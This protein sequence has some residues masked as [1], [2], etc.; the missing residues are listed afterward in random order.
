[1]HQRVSH[2]FVDRVMPPDVFADNDK[3]AGGIKESRRVQSAR[4]LENALMSPKLV[5]Q[6]GQLL[7]GERARWHYPTTTRMK[8]VN[9]I[10]AAHAASTTHGESPLQSAVK[11]WSTRAHMRDHRVLLFAW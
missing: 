1:M 3:R 5:G 2:Y 7:I 4:A 11:R 8:V 9:L 6:Q 10:A